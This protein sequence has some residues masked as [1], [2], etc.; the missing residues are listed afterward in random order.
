MPPAA[1]TSDLRGAGHRVRLAD[2]ALDRGPIVQDRVADTE[3]RGHSRDEAPEL[4][5][6]HSP[7]LYLDS[8]TAK[9]LVADQSRLG[10]HGA[11]Q[12]IQAVARSSAACFDQLRPPIREF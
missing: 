4:V 11:I 6:R 3:G 8:Q 1:E 5:F 12:R 9:L 10:R 7:D 2:K